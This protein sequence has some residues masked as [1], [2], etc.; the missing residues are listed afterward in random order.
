[1]DLCG[2][3]FAERLL[4]CGG[5]GSVVERSAS[6]VSVDIELFGLI[7]D[8]L[9]RVGNCLRAHGGTRIGRGDMVCVAGRTVA[10][11]FGVYVC[12]ARDCVGVFFENQS[13]GAFSENK[14]ASSFIEGDGRCVHV[15]GRGEILAVAESGN[16]KGRYRGFGASADCCIGV[17]SGD[18]AVSLADGSRARCACRG[19]RNAVGVSAVLYCNVSGCDIA[20]HFWDKVRRYTAR[21]A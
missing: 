1:M 12:S 13:S 10:A 20:Y 3:A 4:Y 9:Q 17:S 6:S 14:S 7:C 8:I 5:L 11:D 19:Y 18:E 2:N 16:G 15:L 21:S